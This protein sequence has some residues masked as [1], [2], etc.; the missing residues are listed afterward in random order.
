MILLKIAVI[1]M[2]VVFVFAL[3]AYM[4]IAI[5]ASKIIKDDHFP[6]E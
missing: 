3:V 2:V 6:L 5:I 1:L 4:A